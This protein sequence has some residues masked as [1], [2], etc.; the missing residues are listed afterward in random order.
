MTTQASSTTPNGRKRICD[1]V[2]IRNDFGA[3]RLKISVGNNFVYHMSNSCYKS[4]TLQ[5][6]LDRI[7]VAFGF[8]NN[9]SER[10]NSIC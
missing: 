8:N 7:S 1:A 6:T 5:K 9:I 4:Y 3:K 2:E 10:E